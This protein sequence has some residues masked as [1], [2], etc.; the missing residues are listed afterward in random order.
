MNQQP[1]SSGGTYRWELE[2]TPPHP[3]NTHPVSSLGPVTP[4]IRLQC[5]F[6]STRDA[7]TFRRLLRVRA[8]LL[9]SSQ[10]FTLLVPLDSLFFQMSS[11]YHNTCSASG[12][13]KCCSLDSRVQP[14]PCRKEQKY[15]PH[16]N[17]EIGGL[18][19]ITAASVP[20]PVCSTQ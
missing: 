8:R 19:F 2:V 13:D 18:T 16:Q 3:H 15:K 1:M 6:H 10:S 17:I 14:G 5:S 12:P 9:L 20:R 11:L 4:H 7:L